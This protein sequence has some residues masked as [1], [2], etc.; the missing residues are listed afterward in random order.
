MVRTRKRFYG[1]EVSQS[2][3]NSQ[4]MKRRRLQKDTSFHI[5]DGKRQKKSKER[6][7][8]TFDTRGPYPIECENWG[9][10]NRIFGGCTPSTSTGRSSQS[11]STSS[12]SSGHLNK[13]KLRDALAEL[14]HSGLLDLDDIE[15]VEQY[16]TKCKTSL[17]VFIGGSQEY[18]ASVVRKYLEN[19]SQVPNSV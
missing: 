2:S 15:R 8:F 6:S 10:M 7:F 12:I 14:A 17:H 18:R 3:S 11:R 1:E 9:Q 13:L 5:S 16:V 4:H 19:D